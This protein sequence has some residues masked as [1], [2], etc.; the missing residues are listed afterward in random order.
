VGAGA[1]PL[2]R[3][4]VLAGLAITVL[5]YAGVF[6]VFTYIAPVLTEITGF[7]DAAVSPILLVFGG[8][9][10]LGNLFG[11]KLAD[12]NLDRS[13]LLTLAALTVSLA[14]M[15]FVLQDKTLTIAFVGLVGAAGF[16][17]VAPLQMRVLQKAE[18]A[19]QALASS[20]NIAAFNLGNAI[21]A[22]VG[23]LAIEQGPGLAALPLVA[24]AFPLAAL[25]LSIIA[26]RLDR[27]SPRG[28]HAAA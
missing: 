10:I 4:Q 22:W 13:V 19:G 8:G 7:S 23:G 2:A 1:Q 25:V 20:F 14:V 11:G 27:T 6:T 24:A 21:G 3:P 9:L 12:R 5:G 15:A 26:T 16:A 18:G 28:Q 17:T